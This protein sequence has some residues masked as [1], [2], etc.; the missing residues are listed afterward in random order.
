MIPRANKYH[1]EKAE[2]FQHHVHDSKKE[3]RRC[4]EL[5]LLQK[6]GRLHNLQV[7]VKYNLI[8][9]G[10]YPLLTWDGTKWVEVYDNKSKAKMQ[11]ERPCS[12]VADFVYQI[13]ERT[14]VEDC[15]GLRTEAYKI[16]RKLFRKKY[17]ELW[18]VET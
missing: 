4:N 17:P 11:P 3:A 18:F 16:K 6:A 13:G 5:H 14:F 7:Q 1:A 9:S 10:K 2:C 12:Y 8:D 15:K